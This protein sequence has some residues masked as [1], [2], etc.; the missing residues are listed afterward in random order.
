MGRTDEASLHIHAEPARVFAALS[1]AESVVRWLPPE[2]MTGRIERFD[3]RPGGT[4]RMVLEYRDA[5]GAPGKSSAGE[6]V[7]EG[8][9]VEVVD[10]V[11]LVQEIE[12]ESDDPRCAGVMLMTWEVSAGDDGSDVVF[13]AE[14]VPAGV[15]AEDHAEGLSSS[16]GNLAA[17]LER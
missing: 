2:G 9:F 7:V 12:F 16:L 3:V 15:S 4:Y 10:G 6:D 14:D 13:R 11:R 8:R 17:L 5:A 1:T